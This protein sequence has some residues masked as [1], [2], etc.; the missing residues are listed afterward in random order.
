VRVSGL[1]R[2]GCSNTAADAATVE[3]AYKD[4]AAA[5]EPGASWIKFRNHIAR[6]AFTTEPE[7]SGGRY[8]IAVQNCE[9]RRCFDHFGC[10]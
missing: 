7:V 5:A 9:I 8:M 1:R 2:R 3:P 4:H 6:A 10:Q